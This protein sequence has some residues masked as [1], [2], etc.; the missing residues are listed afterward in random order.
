M[1]F[2]QRKQKTYGAPTPEYYVPMPPVKPPQ[3]KEELIYQKY[4]FADNDE[5]IRQQMAESYMEALQKLPVSGEYKVAIEDFNVESWPDCRAL[6]DYIE[7][8]CRIVDM[9]FR[10]PGSKEGLVHSLYS[11]Q[12]VREALLAGSKILKVYQYNVSENFD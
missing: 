5:Y 6:E 10:I 12:Q 1:C 9:K 11:R 3:I 7:N 8:E 4:L 2:F